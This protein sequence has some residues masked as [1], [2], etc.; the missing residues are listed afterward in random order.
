MRIIERYCKIAR[1]ELPKQWIHAFGPT[2]EALQYIWR[3][4][5]SFDSITTI[6]HVENSKGAEDVWLRYIKKFER[7][8]QFGSLAE[9]L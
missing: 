6:F 5:D 4:I 1:K 7:V 8:R 3:Y 2:V 9:F